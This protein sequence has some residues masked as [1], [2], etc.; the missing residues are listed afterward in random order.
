MTYHREIL[1]EGRVLYSDKLSIK[2]KRGQSV[3]LAAAR[4]IQANDDIIKKLFV[5]R[6]SPNKKVSKKK[7]RNL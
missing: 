5:V 4:L 7:H 6:I 1:F 3:A 2:F